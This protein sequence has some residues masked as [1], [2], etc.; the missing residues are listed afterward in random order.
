MKSKYTNRHIYENELVRLQL[1]VL[2]AILS[3]VWIVFTH[4]DFLSQPT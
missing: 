3:Q 2:L 1:A 4:F